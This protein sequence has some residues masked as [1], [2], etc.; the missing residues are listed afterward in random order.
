MR[1]GVERCRARFR[2]KKSRKTDPKC[3]ACGD[4]LKVR[5]IEEERKRQIAKEPRCYCGPLPFP[6]AIGTSKFCQNH[7]DRLAGIPLDREDEIEFEQLMD[8]PRSG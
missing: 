5:N 4:R 1:C 6:H 2:W 8:T 7:P 3:P